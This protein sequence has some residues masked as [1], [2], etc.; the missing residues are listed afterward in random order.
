LIANGKHRRKTFFQLE[1]EEGTIVG[2]DNLKTYISE[3][4]KNLSGDPAPNHFGMIEY[5]NND[6]PQL[7]SQE[8]RILTDNFTEKE[9]HA[10]IMQMEKNKAPGPE[11]FPAEFY[12][13]FWDVI[14]LDL[15][16]CLPHS[17]TS[18]GGSRKPAAHNKDKLVVNP[19]TGAL[20]Q[21]SI[22]AQ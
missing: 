1:Q 7:S 18:A 9:V 8:N 20:A 17:F 21:K 6:I 10:A 19:T 4:Y 15:P 22:I 12:Q 14:K 16:C 2:Q 11:G 3:Y 5:E 13:K